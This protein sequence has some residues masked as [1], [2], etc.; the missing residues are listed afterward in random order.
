MKLTITSNAELLALVQKLLPLVTSVEFD[1][2]AS[3][4][5]TVPPVIA[6]I[7]ADGDRIQ[8]IKRYRDLTG[9]GLFDAKEALEKNYDRFKT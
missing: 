7:Y 4:L 3:D 9:L 2:A 1:P 5:P 6:K 8:A